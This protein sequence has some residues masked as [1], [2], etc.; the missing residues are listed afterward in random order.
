MSGSVDRPRLTVEQYAREGSWVV[1]ARG[2][3]DADSIAPLDRA[4]QAAV[5]AVPTLV[6]DLGA[7]TFADSSALNLLLVLHHSTAL[8]VAAPQPQLMRVLHVTGADRVL[9]IYPS[10]DHACAA[11]A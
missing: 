8:R 6:V 3:L 10:T 4:T 1:A 7:V 2:E 5:A 9:N 11:Q